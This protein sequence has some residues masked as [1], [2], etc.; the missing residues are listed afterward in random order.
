MLA[1]TSAIPSN[2][3]GVYF[4][5]RERSNLLILKFGGRKQLPFTTFIVIYG[6]CLTLT[7]I[8]LSYLGLWNMMGH[9]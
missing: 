3:Q 1:V 2:L 8:I 4:D 5:S 6:E 7:L 9:F